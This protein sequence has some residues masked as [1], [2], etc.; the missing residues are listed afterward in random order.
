MKKL[1]LCLALGVAAAQ[2][3]AA[4]PTRT[5]TREQA[6]QDIDS[7][8]V[9]ITTIHPNP[10]T[11]TP[12]GKWE[13]Q[14]KTIKRNLPATIT[15]L[16]FWARLSPAVAV[17]GDGHT[18]LYGT[19]E[20]DAVSWLPLII[21]VDPH[22]LEMTSEGRK[23]VDINGL[24]SNKIVE[25][26]LS[27]VSG[28][29]TAYK[30]HLLNQA[31]WQTVISFLF[32]AEKFTVKYADGTV[33]SLAGIHEQLTK[34]RVNR[35]RY[36]LRFDGDAAIFEFNDMSADLE[37]FKRYLAAIFAEIR[38]RGIETLIVDLR[39]NGGGSSLLGDELLRYISPVPFAQFGSTNMRTSRYM[40]DFLLPYLEKLPPTETNEQRSELEAV[41]SGR[42]TLAHFPQSIDNLI[43]PY[44]DSV[45]FTGKTYMLTSLST[46]SSGMCL[47]WGAQRFNAATLVGGDTGG[48]VV[49]FGE[50]ILPP[51]LPNSRLE[52]GVSCKEFFL[53]DATPADRRPVH[54]DISVP[55]DEALKYV[56]ELV[57]GVHI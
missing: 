50:V 35:P 6:I 43:E 57:G 56:L 9:Y 19:N 11:V 32:P 2:Q 16:D 48:F 13:R 15:P 23:I 22:T 34:P 52:M 3:A 24:K 28:E 21:E 20:G 51:R 45:R 37:N 18:M 10:F 5:I 36:T 31:G 1:L 30:A 55:P 44:S 29:Q 12:R 25:K 27:A 54:P 39:N 47:A 41:H 26:T 4:Q 38:R 8:V 42:D 7:A 33:Q 14:I 46:F 49:H 17:L 40:R 53:W